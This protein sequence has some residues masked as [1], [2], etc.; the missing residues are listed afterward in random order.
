MCHESPALEHP[1]SYR[2]ADLIGHSCKMTPT[3]S[4]PAPGLHALHLFLSPLF[5]QLNQK[6]TFLQR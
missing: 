6:W 1:G 2:I 5:M 3:V 4:A